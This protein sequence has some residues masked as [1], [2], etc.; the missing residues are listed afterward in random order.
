[1]AKIKIKLSELPNDSTI[2]IGGFDYKFKGL[3]KRKSQFGKQEFFVFWS[4]DAK[5]EKTFERYKFST[6]KIKKDGEKY[7]W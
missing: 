1:M 4:E 7:Y 2:E 3:E 5:Q 6:I